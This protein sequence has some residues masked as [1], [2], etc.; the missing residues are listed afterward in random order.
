MAIQI[1]GYFFSCISY[2]I[3]KQIYLTNIQSHIINGLINCLASLSSTMEVPVLFFVSTEHR[4]ALKD[5]FNWLFKLFSSSTTTNVV[6]LTNKDT[7]IIIKNEQ[8]KFLN[9]K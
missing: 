8:N 2:K 6:A 4:L 7:E 1:F 3:V 5:Q 9:H